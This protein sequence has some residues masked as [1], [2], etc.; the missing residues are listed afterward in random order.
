MIIVQLIGST[1]TE[2]GLKVYCALDTDHYPKGVRVTD[3]E[4]K[5]INISPAAYASRA[6][7]PLP[8]QGSLP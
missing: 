6:A 1:T 2:K 5:E 4:M 3:R 7:L 8:M